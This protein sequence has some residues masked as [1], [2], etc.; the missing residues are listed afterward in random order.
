M[1]ERDMDE[2]VKIES[3]FDEALDTLLGVDEDDDEDE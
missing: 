1:P 2:P 3:D